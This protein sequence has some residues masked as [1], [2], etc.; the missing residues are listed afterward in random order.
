MGS[1]IRPSTQQTVDRLVGTAVVLG[2]SLALARWVSISSSRSHSTRSSFQEDP[3]RTRENQ[4]EHE[5]ECRRI[6]KWW[7][8]LIAL[9]RI[10]YG[11][12]I[13]SKG[14]NKGVTAAEKSV[15][16]ATSCNDRSRTENDPLPPDVQQ[17][18]HRGTV[19][20]R[21][22]QNNILDKQDDEEFEHSG[23]CQCGS[24]YFVVSSFAIF[25][26]LN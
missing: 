10:W 18:N 11:R 7:W 26:R 3:L 5:E 6:V 9:Q 16:A 4:N 8:P 24:I 13:S 1:A 22:I 21:S 19:D 14:D 17:R 2:L 12:R 25:F 23:S 20:P 15:L